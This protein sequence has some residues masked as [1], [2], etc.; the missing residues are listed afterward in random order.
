MHSDNSYSNIYPIS[1][2]GGWVV[3]NPPSNTGDVS[4]TPGQ[5]TKIP[6]TMEQ[7]NPSAA[8][9]EPVSSRAFEPQG[10]ILYPKTKT[11]QEVK[12]IESH[13]VMSNSLQPTV[14]GILQARILSWIAIPFSRGSSEPRD[15]SQVSQIADGF[16]LPAEPPG[17]PKAWPNK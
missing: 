3:K 16:F 12:W 14:H 13:S 10:K 1:F 6:H 5:R 17:K 4:L 9:T 8:T 11:W 7:L 2:P 15:W